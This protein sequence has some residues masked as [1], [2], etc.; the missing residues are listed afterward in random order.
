L[1]PGLR[2]HLVCDDGI[3]ATSVQRA[4]GSFATR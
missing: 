2:L 1:R 4:A 3:D